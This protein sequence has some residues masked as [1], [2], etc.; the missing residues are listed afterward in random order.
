MGLG[1]VV[2]KAVKKVTNVAKKAAP[3]A[4]A[5]AGLYYGGSALYDAFGAPTVASAADAAAGAAGSTSFLDSL[6]KYA[7]IV[8]AVTPLIAGGLQYAGANSANEA[9]SQEALLNRAFQEQMRATQYQ[10]A[11]DDMKKAGLNPMLTYSQGGAGN[12]NGAV[13]APYQ[14]AAGQA[15]ST[16]LQARQM[17]AQTKNL[18]EANKLIPAQLANL[19]A[20]NPLLSAQANQAAEHAMLMRTQSATEAARTGRELQ[21]IEL[22][23]NR[24][25]LEQQRFKLEKRMA[26]SLAGLQAAQSRNFDA[27][28]AYTATRNT[29]EGYE[30]TRRRID[31]DARGS[32][33]GTI[34]R[35]GGTFFRDTF[36]PYGGN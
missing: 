12:L 5:A 22:D 27:N 7:P 29:G 15:A 25:K 10:T 9:N 23:A 4:A 14:N 32:L 11:V 33:V 16:A 18:E 28:S 8:S 17:L 3:Y 24:F 35:G 6:N 1:S 21:N 30:N 36:S 31:S 2:K 19:E 13:A 26:L 34:L 20:Q